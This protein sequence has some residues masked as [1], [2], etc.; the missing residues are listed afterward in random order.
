MIENTN[1]KDKQDLEE[2]KTVKEST[3][4]PSKANKVLASGWDDDDII[5]I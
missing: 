4:S 2:E 3:E 5:D 1:N